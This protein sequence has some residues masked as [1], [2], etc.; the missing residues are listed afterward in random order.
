LAKPSSYKRTFCGTRK[1]ALIATN[2]RQLKASVREADGQ[3]DNFRLA[4]HPP[5]TPQRSHFS[6]QSALSAVF[7]S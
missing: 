2:C 1:S 6:A 7:N 4:D 3:V 5:G